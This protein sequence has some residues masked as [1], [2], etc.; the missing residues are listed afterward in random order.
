[1]IIKGHG[2]NGLDKIQG[3]VCGDIRSV[4][5]GGNPKDCPKAVEVLL[6]KD[7]SKYYD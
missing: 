3:L 7:T 6:K 4:R 1:M 2:L 5:N